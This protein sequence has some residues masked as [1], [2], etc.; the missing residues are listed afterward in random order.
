M[1]DTHA[2]AAAAAP[3]AAASGG[4]WLVGGAVRDGL[5]HR[6]CD[7]VDLAV[8][9]DAESFARTLAAALDAPAFSYSERFSAWRIVCEGGHVDVTPLRG[10]T[11]ADDLRGRDFT[12][13]AMARA[14]APGEGAG[15]AAADAPPSAAPLD[16]PPSAAAVN[17]PPSAAAADAPPGDPG[18]ASGALIDPCGGLADL[19]ARRLVACAPGALDDDPVRVVRLARL[20]HELDLTVA[21][22]VEQAA[23]AAA[24]RLAA[25]SPERLEHEL[26]TLL[27]LPCVAPA[28][29]SLADLGALEVVLPEVAACRGVTQ[30]PYH[31]LD[32]FEHTLEALSFLSQV[33][34]A[35]GGARYLAAPA[36]C[37]LPGAPALAPLAWAVLLHDVGKPLA[38][39]VDDQG[40]VMFLSHDRLGEQIARDICRRLRMSRR[41]EQFLAELVRQH[42]RLG[43]L[44]REMPLTRRALVRFRRDAQPFVFEA[45]VL[46]LAD[47]VATR[48]ERTP[49]QSL[50]RHFRIARDVFGDTPSPPRRLLGGEEVMSL[51]GVGPGATVGRALE[52]LQEEIE[53]GD[54]ATP[55][56]ARAFLRGWWAHEQEGARDA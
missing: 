16:A 35:L 22:G 27:G 9:G 8:A 20:R 1:L 33:V 12:V 30:N 7:D 24:G 4:A 41:F 47:R 23:R 26:S 54:V 53:C 28:V 13:N 37:G 6:E 50:A 43:F 25:A 5:L 40:R 55:D 52:V 38:R 18:A 21:P 49:P 31:H 46:S 2:I 10:P 32:V 48:G 45:I 39:Q 42:L 29:R 19:R 14:L 15:A 3:A 11:I 34:S 51:L 17:A 44:V 56:Q 36:E